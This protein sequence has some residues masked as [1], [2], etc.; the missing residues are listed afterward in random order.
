MRVTFKGADTLYPCRL[1]AGVATGVALAA[2]G[3]AT[4][5]PRRAHSVD[6]DHAA[7]MSEGYRHVLL[8]GASVAAP[9]GTAIKAD[10]S[11]TAL[12]DLSMGF[13]MADGF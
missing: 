1:Q 10:R 3:L 12:V 4:P 13:A 9:R 5:G 8:D 7:L 2:A 6:L 11:N